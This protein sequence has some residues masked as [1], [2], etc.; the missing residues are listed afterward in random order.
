MS[1]FSLRLPY[2]QTAYMHKKAGLFNHLQQLLLSHEIM[3]RKC[4]K[5]VA[6]I[7]DQGPDVVNGLVNDNEPIVNLAHRPQFHGRAHD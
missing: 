4:R 6:Q 3:Y 5:F 7:L 1:N 2:I